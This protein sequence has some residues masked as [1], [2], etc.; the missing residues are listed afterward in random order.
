MTG[1][2]FRIIKICVFHDI[3]VGIVAG[4]AADALV[5]RTEFIAFAQRQ[6]IWLKSHVI[7]VVR[8]IRC[9]FLPRPM[10]LTAE[11]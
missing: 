11:G 8:A 6:S 10:A 2:T 5:E 4:S 3:L 9:D 1:L 7:Y